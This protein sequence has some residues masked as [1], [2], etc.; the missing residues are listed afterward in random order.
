MQLTVNP[1]IGNLNPITLNN[2]GDHPA[3]R[4]IVFIS[5][6]KHLTSKHQ[7]PIHLLI[8]NLYFLSLLMY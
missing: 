2:F 4:G 1:V 7:V 8:K 5:G 3:V 6:P